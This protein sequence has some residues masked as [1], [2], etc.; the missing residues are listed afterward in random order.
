ME[1]LAPL[2][3]TGVARALIAAPTLYLLVN[4]AHIMG[5]GVLYGSILALDLRILGL[6]RSVPLHVIAG[7]LSRMAATGAGLAI[8]T[9]LCLVSVRPVEYAGNA[10]FLAKLALVAVG[11][12]HALVLH[13]GIGWRRA[14]TDGHASAALR[15]SALASIIIWTSAIVAGRWIGFL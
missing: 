13:R 11:L 4:A 12:A 6:N 7:F 5:I 15:L 9:G 3:E 8:L 14:T 10:A 1:W 2:A